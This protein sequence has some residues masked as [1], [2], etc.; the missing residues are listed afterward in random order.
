VSAGTIILIV[1]IL[2]IVAVAATVVSTRMRRRTTERNLVGPEYDRLVDEV[3]PR[4]AREEFGKRRRRV[5]ELGISPLIAE[6]RTG[7]AGQWDTAQQQFVDAPAEAV[8]AAGALITA[9]AADRGYEVTDHDQLSTDLS[10][11]HG[12]YLDG[13]RNARQT[14]ARAGEATTEALRR[15]LLGYRGL[16]LDLLDSPEGDGLAPGLEADPGTGQVPAQPPWKQ[17]TQGRHWKTRQQE[18]SDVAASRP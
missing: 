8:T 14:T 5:D 17:V 11:Y 9:V 6:R 3:G 7:Y 16:F 10:V 13:Y 15:A 4:K 18:S 1:V 2:A 12:R